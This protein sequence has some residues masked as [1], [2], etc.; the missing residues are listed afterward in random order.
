MLP[1][2]SWKTWLQWRLIMLVHPDFLL[3]ATVSPAEHR[4][5]A[6]P[7]PG[8]ERVMLDRLGA[9]RARAASLARYAP[10]SVYPAH[11]HPGSEEILVLSGTFSD[12]SGEYGPGCYLRNPPGSAHQPSSADGALIFVKLSHLAETDT[13]TVRVDTR[14]PSTWRTDGRHEVC[15]L[16]AADREQVSLLR[17]PPGHTLRLDAAG[18]AELLVIEGRSIVGTTVLAALGWLRLP[19]GDASELHAGDAGTTIYLKTGHLTGLAT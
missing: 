3:R 1:Q 18:G 4:W 17:L 12:G 13:R 7:Q 9:E 11:G 2:R 5:V 10:A 6:S 16:Y 15:V 19:P 8:V 14:D